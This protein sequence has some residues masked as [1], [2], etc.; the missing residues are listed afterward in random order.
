MVKGG[1]QQDNFANL[2]YTVLF[3]PTTLT[4]EGGRAFLKKLVVC[5]G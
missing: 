4:T 1:D 2:A 5:G 3:D